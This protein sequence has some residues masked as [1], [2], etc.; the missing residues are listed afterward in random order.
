M[1]IYWYTIN[2]T[3]TVRWHMAG[4][5]AWSVTRPATAAA[6]SVRYGQRMEHDGRPA[7]V[8]FH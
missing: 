8:Y 7:A 3:T 6:S 2:N 5:A 4:G 1:F